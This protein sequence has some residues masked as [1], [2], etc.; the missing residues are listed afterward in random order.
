MAMP[1]RVLVR[2]MIPQAF[3]P[4][5]LFAIFLDLVGFGMTFP[6]VQLRAQQYGAPGWLIGIV[7]ASYYP[8]QMVASPMWG[9]LSDRIGRKPVLLV[10]G[11]ISAASMVIYALGGGVLAMLLSRMAAGLGAANVVTAQAYIAD[12]IHEPERAAALGRMGAAVSLGLVA[13]PV[14]GGALAHVGGN[15]LLGMVAAFASAIGILWIWITVPFQPPIERSTSGPKP[16]AFSLLAQSPSL[17]RLFL[18]AMTGWL[19]LASLEGTFGRLLQHNLGYGQLEFGILLSLE[20]GVAFVQG[21]CYSVVAS[22]FSVAALLR[23]SFLLQAVGLAAMPFGTGLGPLVVFCILFG[24][25]LGIAGPT[26]NAAASDLTS[27]DRQ[28]ELFGLL[29][30]SRATGFLIGPI[31][32][33]MLFDWNVSAPYLA[34]GGFMVLAAMFVSSHI[35]RHTRE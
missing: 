30:S 11:G 17:Q 18:V 27:P 14:V 31:I 33:G 29:Q 16:G 8:V 12:T 24:M 13:G 7:L 25:G 28:G 4:P 20:A 15:F 5:L 21:I 26:I 23:T 9:R 34:A 32:G 10:C 3:E 19:A 6:D 2:A 22:H 35:E 1:K